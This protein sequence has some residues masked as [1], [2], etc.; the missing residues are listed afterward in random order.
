VKRNPA[1]AIAEALADTLRGRGFRLTPQRLAVIR[2]FAAGR[3][4]S[5]EEVHTAL[6]RDWPSMSLATVYKTIALLKAQG[7][8]LEIDFGAAE[9]RY[10]ILKPNPHPHAVCLR[11]GA[12]ADPGDADLTA[13][14]AQ[15]ARDTGF[16]ITSL[17]LDFFGLCPECRGRAK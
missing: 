13:L 4:P 10:D 7:L 1:P 5:A 3:H 2:A 16:E 12:V 17:R 9:H 15:A 8:I 11:C 14:T 6:A